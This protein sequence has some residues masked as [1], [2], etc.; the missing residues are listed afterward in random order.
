MTIAR[1]CPFS[2]GV[3]ARLAGKASV[4]GCWLRADPGEKDR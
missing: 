4:A 2:A 3:R 1:A